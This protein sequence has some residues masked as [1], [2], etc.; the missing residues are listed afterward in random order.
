MIAHGV[1]VFID[2]FMLQNYKN[3]SIIESNLLFFNNNFL[4]R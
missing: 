2:T 4:R 3:F 1:F